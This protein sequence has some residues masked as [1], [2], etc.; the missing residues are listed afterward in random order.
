LGIKSTIPLLPVV[1]VPRFVTADEPQGH[2]LY[3]ELAQKMDESLRVL[4]TLTAL[5]GFLGSPPGGY[6]YELTSGFPAISNRALNGRTGKLQHKAS[7][8]RRALYPRPEGQNYPRY[9]G[10]TP[11]SDSERRMF[12]S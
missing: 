5:P 6:E 1:G 12:C 9:L 10:K 8:A 11:Q 7:F 2:A 3:R 4:G